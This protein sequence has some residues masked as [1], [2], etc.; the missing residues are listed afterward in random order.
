MIL[1]I[2]H[3][4]YIKNSSDKVSMLTDIEINGQIKTI[5]VEVEDKYG[6]FLSPERSDYALV[7]IL[8]YA[9]RNKHDII[10]ETPVTEELLYNIRKILIPTLVYSDPRNYPVTIIADIASPLEKLEY[11]E[12]ARG[13]GRNRTFLRR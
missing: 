7:G 11:A 1:I 9:L 10:C 3:K 12:A 5:S 13:G 6:K 8:A 2:I 4:A